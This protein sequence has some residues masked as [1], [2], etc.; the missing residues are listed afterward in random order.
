MSPADATMKAL[1]D[2]AKLMT[3]M[4]S[5]LAA[6]VAWLPPAP[7][8]TMGFTTTALIP[9]Y[10]AALSELSSHASYRRPWFKRHRLGVQAVV[11]ARHR[12]HPGKN[13]HGVRLGEVGVWAMPSPP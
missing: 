11:F 8:T 10:S 5:T 7:A 6:V 13:E 1:A 2:L 3:A 4:S 12:R 9:D